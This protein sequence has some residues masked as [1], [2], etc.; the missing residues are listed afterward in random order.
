MDKLLEIL[1]EINDSLDY[2]NEDGLIDNELIDSVEL[3][4]LIA[5]IEDAYDISIDMEDIIPENFNSVEA[6]YKLI[7]RLQNE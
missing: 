5:E 3:M 4:Q 1:R 6:M 7:D 2:M